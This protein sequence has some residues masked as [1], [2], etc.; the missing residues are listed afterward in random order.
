MKKKRRRERIERKGERKCSVK[1]KEELLR[2]RRPT[3]LK[4]L[5]NK[6]CE[7]K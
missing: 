7:L 3:K 6:E 5:T 1:C 4:T 2:R